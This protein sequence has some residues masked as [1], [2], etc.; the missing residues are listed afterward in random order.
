MCND[1]VPARGIY[2]VQAGGWEQR[3]LITIHQMD[4][5]SLM[6]IHHD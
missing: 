1:A 5:Y 6:E 4:S 3:L 2:C